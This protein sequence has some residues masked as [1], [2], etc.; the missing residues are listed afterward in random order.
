MATA[1]YDPTVTGSPRRSLQ[2][3]RISAF[4]ALK[5]RY[6]GTALGILWSFTNPLLMTA[7]YTAIFG[8]AFS[9][10]YD[11]SVVRYVLAAFVGLVVVTFFMNATSE[12]LPS[13]VANGSLLNKIALPPEIFPLA[14]VAANVFQQGVTSFPIVFVISLVITHDP[15][16]AV[17]VPVV[18][19]SVVLMV[20]GVA[21]A[22][23]A[24]YVF[25]RDL[26]HLWEIASFILWFTSP[27]FYPIDV[28]PPQIRPWYVL[29]PVGQAVTALREV[30]IARGPIHY[31]SIVFALVAG[32]VWFAVGAWLFRAK[33][34]DFMDLL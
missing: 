5:V 33:R 14:S 25:F 8:T 16:R 15:L 3:V 19:A 1:L 12:A 26:P 6:R 21:L 10:F 27:L 13:V 24:L 4:R 30:T 34:R 23:S 17:L 2:L 29:N 28:V 31:R 11:G 9:K 18:L 22:L 20:T 7:V 32:I